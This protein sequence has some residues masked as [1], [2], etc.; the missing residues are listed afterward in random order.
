MIS[1]LADESLPGSGQ[2]CELGQSRHS[3]HARIISGLPRKQTI[4][5]P[6]ALRKSAKQTHTI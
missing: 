4:Q 2:M 1:N 6:S 3:D 5:W